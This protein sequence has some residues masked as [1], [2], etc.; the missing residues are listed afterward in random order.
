MI[1]KN[2]LFYCRLFKKRFTTQNDFVDMNEI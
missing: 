1:R 2:E